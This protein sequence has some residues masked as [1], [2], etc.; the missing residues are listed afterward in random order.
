MLYCLIKF[1][2]RVKSDKDA[3][4]DSIDDYLGS[5]LRNGQIY[6]DYF[7]TWMG[8]V[9]CA[10]VF[11]ARPDSLD[12]RYTSKWGLEKLDK[13][14][15]QYKVKIDWKIMDD[16]LKKRYSHWKSAKFLYLHPHA[17]NIG[18]P[19]FRGDDGRAIPPYLIP[20]SDSDREYLFFWFQNYFH[21]D[22]IWIYSGELE[23]PAYK[24]MADPTSE[25]SNFG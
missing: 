22:R 15:S 1:K 24:Q 20:I 3:F 4:E 10:H 12:K 13:I 14:E 19:V 17:F 18:N 21:H 2:S 16:D 7:L 25:L 11:L 8:G 5:L 9:L 23:T 6:G